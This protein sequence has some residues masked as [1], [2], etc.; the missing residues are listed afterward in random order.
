MSLTGSAASSNASQVSAGFGNLRRRHRFALLT[1]YKASG[2]TV[3]TPMWFARRDGRLYMITARNAA[4]LARI[5]RNPQ[6]TVGPCRSQGR[7]LGPPTAATAVIL[8]PE[9]S[10][11]AARALS[12]RYFLPSW[13]I[14]KFLRRRG[15]GLPPVYVQLTPAEQPER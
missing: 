5:R 15:G 4:K 13:V 6:T 1:T 2:E 9:A 3:S 11:D 10:D 8:D 12:R 7:P 14:E